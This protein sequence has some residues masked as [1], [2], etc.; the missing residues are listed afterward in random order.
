MY[1]V[2]C[3]QIIH[4]NFLI[5]NYNYVTCFRYTSVSVGIYKVSY[6][7]D[8]FIFDSSHNDETRGY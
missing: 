4:S 6:T 3:I 5:I 2:Y 8:V 7:Y 1:T